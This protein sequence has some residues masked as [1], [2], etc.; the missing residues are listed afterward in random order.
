MATIL[1]IDDNADHCEL[2]NRVLTAY[3]YDVLIAGDAETGLKT[4]VERRPNLILLDLGLPDVDGQTL[5]GWMR[6]IPVLAHTPIVAVTAWPQET[7]RKMVEVYGCNGYI[8]KPIRVADFVN[9]V[10]AYLR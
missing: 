8:G 10:A 5:V 3:G 4:A 9:Q 6:H 2:V 7:A 1:V